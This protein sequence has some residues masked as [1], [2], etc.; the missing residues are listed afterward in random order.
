[1]IGRTKDNS[2]TFAVPTKYKLRVFMFL[3]VFGKRQIPLRQYS[4]F[5]QR[6]LDVVRDTLFCLFVRQDPH[7]TRDSFSIL[8]SRRKRQVHSSLR[9]TEFT[10]LISLVHPSQNVNRNYIARVEDRVSQ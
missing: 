5:L 1:M 7:R 8:W 9:L 2:N 10:A 3:D 4:P 6:L